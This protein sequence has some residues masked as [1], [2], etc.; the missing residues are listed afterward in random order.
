[1]VDGYD[2]VFFCFFI[3]VKKVFKLFLWFR[4]NIVFDRIVGV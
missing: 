2:V 1:M 3:I 4:G